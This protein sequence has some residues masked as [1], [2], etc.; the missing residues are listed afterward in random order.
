M[1]VG[2]LGINSKS[3]SY[4][5]LFEIAGHTCYFF[6]ED[7]NLVFNINNK[8]YLTEEPTLLEKLVDRKKISGSTEVTE[9]IKNSDIIFSLIDCPPNANGTLDVT[10][11]FA[12]IQTFY[13]ASHLDISLYG[14]HFI[15]SSVVNPGDSKRIHEKIAQFGVHYGY[16]PNFLTEGNTY[17][18]LENNDLFVLGT[19]SDELSKTFTDL[20]RSIKTNSKV[21][22]MSYESAEL[23]KLGISAIV[24]NKIVVANMLGDFMTSMGLEKEIPM[25]LSSISDDP[26]IGKQHMTYGL[27]YGGPHLGKEIRVLSEFTET[28]KVEINI[29]DY[30]EK[31]NQEHLT[32]LKYYYMTLN[33]DKNRPFVIESLGYKKGSKIIDDSQR[34]KLCIE[35]LQE[36]YII[37]VV[38]DLEIA[39]KFTSLSESYDNRLRFYKKGTTPE[40]IKIK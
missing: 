13:L 3:V 21:Y 6:D 38:E 12:K 32:F 17:N 30:L 31:A 15:L 39:N 26:R 14:K 37:N 28:K 35:L 23:V 8:V 4:S 34:F 29:F 5:I 9:V 27:G 33:P 2:F 25:V 22:I 10:E 16:L 24:A 11:I 7:E 1:N 40:G 19:D 36:G 18:S 20:I